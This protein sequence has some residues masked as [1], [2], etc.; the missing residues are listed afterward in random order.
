MRNE[1][2]GAHREAA[3]VGIGVFIG[4]LPLYGFHLALCLATGW[5]LG[6][7]RLKMYVAA[8]VSN[9]LFAPVLLF[10]ELQIGSVL[11]RGAAYPL[12]FEA[13]RTTQASIFGVD[14]LVGSVVVGLGLG[15][16]LAALTYASAR[17]TG[18]DTHFL[19]LVHA[20]SDR[21]V[22]SSITAWEFARGKLR[23]DPLY[24]AVVAGGLLPS[25]GTL[26][27]VGCGSGLTLA[28]LA[29]ASAR[30]RD[31]TWPARWPPPPIFDRLVG[32][33]LRPHAAGI[34]H[35]ALGPDAEIRIADACDGIADASRVV[36]LCDVLHMIP[37]EGQARIL[38]AAAASVR[39]A[40]GGVILVREADA[41]GG[42]R[43]A[44]V[45]FGNRL[46]ALAFGHW[47]QRFYFRTVDGWLALFADQGLS[48][49]TVPNGDGTPFAS[50][51]FRITVPPAA[52]P[53][54]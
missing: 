38:A 15:V 54:R 31:G 35:A 26:I 33:E 22:T 42:W 11:R 34:A 16:V 18:A 9:P 41:G 8:N 23:G 4:C 30:W 43:F 53:E 24:R 40:H 47:G 13:V 3:A 1:G 51:L 27:D 5:L 7:N 6:L 50:V 17:A 46:K 49:A 14:I 36:L 28:M 29:E 25:G 20:A 2:A 39:R 32:L 48:A 45:R 21:F 44:S 37:T 19:N 12:S 52:D 10:L